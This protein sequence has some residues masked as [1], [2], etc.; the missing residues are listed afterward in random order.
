MLTLPPGISNEKYETAPRQVI[1]HSPI[2]VDNASTVSKLAAGHHMDHL[3]IQEV[4]A[5]DWDLLDNAGAYILQHTDS[6]RTRFKA[7]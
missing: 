4:S 6:S 7:T 3:D 5:L 2:F 1:E